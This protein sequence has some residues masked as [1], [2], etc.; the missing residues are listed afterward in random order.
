MREEKKVYYKDLNSKEGG[1]PSIL[2]EEI[3]EI[4]Y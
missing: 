2:E 3:M 1:K 4:Y